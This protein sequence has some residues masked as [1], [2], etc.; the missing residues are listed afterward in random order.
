M[1]PADDVLDELVRYVQPHRGCAISLTESDPKATGD[2]NWI[3][4]SGTM[5]EP[6]LERFG[7]KVAEL[8]KSDPLIDWSKAVVPPSPG[9]RKQVTRW[10]AEAQSG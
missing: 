8:R 7:R 4:G 3:A 2:T 5:D 9:A 10:F 1:K 6:A